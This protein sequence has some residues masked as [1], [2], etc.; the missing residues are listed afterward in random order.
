MKNTMRRKMGEFAISLPRSKEKITFFI[1]GD[2]QRNDKG[3]TD[4][5][6]EFNVS[7]EF[8]Y[9]M[10][11]MLRDLKDKYDIEGIATWRTT[12]WKDYLKIKLFVDITQRDLDD[13]FEILSKY[14][15]RYQ[16]R[17][18]FEFTKDGNYLI[19][20]KIINNL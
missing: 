10:T 8:H 5:I 4:A 1:W 16:L 13:I 12:R 19:N 2:I 11:T 3:G 15:F 18:S 9:M 17:N 7:P 20:N 6:L 14:K